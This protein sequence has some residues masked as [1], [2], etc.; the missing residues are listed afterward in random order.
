MEFIYSIL[1][2]YFHFLAPTFSV[3]YLL[4][5]QSTN[6][7]DLDSIDREKIARSVSEEDT[8]NI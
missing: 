5:D 1:G 7:F 8:A 4:V 6:D 2:I 3:T